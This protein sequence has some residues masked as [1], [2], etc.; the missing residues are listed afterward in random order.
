MLHAWRLGFV[1]PVTGREMAF[2]RGVPRD[3]WRLV[4]ALARGVQRVG[5]VGLPGSGKSA[6][7]RDLEA[8]GLPVWSADQAVTELYRPGADGWHLLRGRFGE[9]FVPDV[10][11]GVDKRAL[12][13]AMRDSEGFRRE[14][15]EM[16]YPLVRHRLGDFWR[17]NA[18]ARVAFAEVPMLLEAGWTGGGRADLVLGVRCPREVRHARLAE[19]G[20]PPETIALMDSWQWPEEKKMAA[21]AVTVDNS[22]NLAALARSL[23]EALAGLRRRRV[24]AVRDLLAWLRAQAYMA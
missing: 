9:R 15:M 18:R 5:V 2:T 19:R 24:R 14:L 13:A 10:D 8:R 11:R 3:F 21:C 16:L 6:V 22:K 20:W 17:Q 1:H 7:L 4:L 23:D 12:F